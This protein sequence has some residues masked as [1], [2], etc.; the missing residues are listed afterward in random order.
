[1]VSNLLGKPNAFFG[2]NASFEGLAAVDK[3][4]SDHFFIKPQFRAK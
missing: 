4:A 1:M 3:F 2:F